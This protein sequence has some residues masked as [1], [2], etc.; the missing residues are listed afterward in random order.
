[1]LSV[2]F[3]NVLPV[4]AAEGLA[5]AAPGSGKPGGAAPTGG[6]QGKPGRAVPTDDG[7]GKP[8]GAAPT[9]GGPGLSLEERPRSRSGGARSAGRPGGTHAIVPRRDEDDAVEEVLGRLSRA[10]DS[11]DGATVEVAVKDAC[12]AFRQARI[13]AFVPILVERRAR[14]ALDAAVRRRSSAPEEGNP[15]SAP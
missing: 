2:T 1:M 3:R 10:Y 15:L 13:R 7:S 12:Q 11:L 6:G 9:G 5:R 14:A 4:R 8:G